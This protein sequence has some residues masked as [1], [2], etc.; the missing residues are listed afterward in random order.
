MSE[1][2]YLFSEFPPISEKEW[3]Q[4]IQ[5]ELKGADYSKT[6]VWESLEGIHVK[7]FY[8]KDS[9]EYLEIPLPKNDYSI[10]QE[11]FID[12]PTIANKISLD[13]LSKGADAILF[14]ASH[15]FDIDVLFQ[16]F[17]S[18]KKEVT[19]YFNNSFLSVN[20]IQS[21]LNYFDDNR[22]VILQDPISKLVKSGNWHT[23]KNDD[24]NTIQ[25]LLKEYPN[26]DILNIDTSIYQNAGANIIQ[27]IAYALSHANEYLT[28][29]GEKIAPVLHF[30]FS[31]GSNYFF[32]IAK[33]RAFRY[34][35]G[36]LT[37]N[38]G[39]I[40]AK[41]IAKPG[42]RNKTIYDNNV[43]M[44]RTTTEYMSAIL[45]GA[46]TVVSSAY[47]GIFKKSNGFSERIARNQLLILKEEN[48]FINAQSF[49]KGSYYIEALTIELA[50]KSLRLFKDIEKSG[51]FLKQLE[52]GIIQ[53]KIQQAALKEQQ[54][55]DSGEITLLGT[56][57]FPNTDET[58]KNKLD[59]FPFV[60]KQ[61]KQTLIQPLL[62]K[63]LSEEIEQKRLDSE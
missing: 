1:E 31:I 4:Q 34:L 8:H 60:K 53:S 5:M 12:D 56:N 26:K 28:T 36:K 24:F 38:K 44:L 41:I 32:E 45:G 21:L 15:S 57:K 25:L 20:F 14:T 22:V 55:F 54:L 40:P 7:P 6:L 27:Q 47:D 2:N 48:F 49:P 52:A 46:N 10:C 19:L 59:L 13:A 63:R 51:G 17:N 11:V 18:I 35:W 30:E 3:K 43:N 42:F 37:D 39:T 50:K 23:N 29:F 9:F 61:K 62:P 33:L 16:G 58:I